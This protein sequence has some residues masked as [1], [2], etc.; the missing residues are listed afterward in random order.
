MSMNRGHSQVVEFIYI[1]KQL[2][3]MFPSRDNRHL[4]IKSKNELYFF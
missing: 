3:L 2:E 1:H 4:K